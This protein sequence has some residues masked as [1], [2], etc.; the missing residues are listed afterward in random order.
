M[1]PV[2]P[3]SE[4]KEEEEDEELEAQFNLFTRLTFQKKKNQ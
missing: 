1:L 3:I 2:L 4:Q